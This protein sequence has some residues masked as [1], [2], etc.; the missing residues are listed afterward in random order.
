[1]SLALAS[2]LFLLC[3]ALTLFASALLTQGLDELGETLSIP[4]GLLGLIT[5]LAANAPEISSSVAALLSG[6]RDVGLGV[7]LGSN[8][9]NL[10]ALLGLSAVVAGKVRVRRSG[11]ALHGGV[12]L[13]ITLTGGA[14]V[15]GWLSPVVSM[16][17][18]VTA[19]LPYSMVLAMHPRRLRA[20]PLPAWLKG[21]LARG[22]SE[23]DY[24]EQAAK[25]Q[26]P[27][28]RK[29]HPWRPPLVITAALVAIV[30]GSVGMVKTVLVIAHAWNVPQLLVG[31]LVLAALTGLPNAYTA[32]RLARNGQG[33]AVVSEAFNS[34]TLNIMIGVGL[35]ALIFGFG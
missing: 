28:W 11:L 1:M 26:V 8:M 24:E 17:L 9:F 31:T 3:L 15:L 34:N 30:G 14:L 25:Q 4:A 2:I 10:A 32:I 22:V 23:C 5:A 13:W 21:W 6:A 12:D 27:N 33:A 19:F 16:A 20:L 18:M 29:S 7:V 35:P